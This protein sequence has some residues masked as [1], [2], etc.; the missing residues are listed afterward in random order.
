MNDPRRT[1]LLGVVLILIGRGVLADETTATP[2]LTG[3]RTVKDAA[4]RTIVPARPGVAGRTGYLGASTIRDDQGRLTIEQVQPDSPAS[5]AGVQPGDVIARVDGEPVRTPDLFREAI[6]AHAPGEPVKLAL[7]RRGQPIESTATLAA[8]SRP[9]SANTRRAYLGIAMGEA[10]EGE[11]VRVDRVEPD[12][13][14]ATAGFKPG[15]RIFQIDG[16]DFTTA[17]KLTEILTEKQ[18]GN[19]FEVT[20]RRDGAEVVLR[21]KLAA[22]QGGFRPGGAGAPGRPGQPGQPG[23]P[24]GG[25]GRGQGGQMTIPLW[26]KP[27][28]RVAVIG[29]EFPDV[30]HNAKV[31]VSDW[32]EAWLGEGTY[33]GKKSPT[34]QD[35]RGSLND[36]FVEQSA[37]AFRLKGKVFDWIEV[38]KK[39][40]DYILGSGTTSITAVLVEA[41]EKV[42]ARD[43]QDALK[44]FDG[45]LFVYA[46]ET[47]RGNRGSVYYP[48]AGTIRSFQSKRWSYVL[49]PEGGPRQ[50]ML[51]GVVKEFAQ[52]LGLPDLAA[53][54]EDR[55]SEGLGPWSV[56]SNPTR[57]PQPQHLDPWSKEKLG[58]LK[59]TVIDP[60]VKQKLILGPIEGSA[61]ECFKV[62][63]RPDG[64][65]YFLLENR[66]K[67]GFDEGLPAEGL[68]IWRVVKDR[69]SLVESHGIE[70]PTGP[71]VRLDAVPY[72][73]PA[74][75]AFTSET[76]PSS[77]STLGGG[78]PV[79]I[80]NIRRLPDGRIAFQ[81]GYDYL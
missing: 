18:P 21:P 68:L 49:I 60:T 39:R 54:T 78:L 35:V 52:M 27:E 2:D 34:D 44:D 41:L 62:L 22:D 65:E 72:P 43:G 30:K 42:V 75:H 58:W 46:G 3:Y 40:A 9:R 67:Q 13:P 77:R 33:H 11:G 45:V 10:K 69:P 6:Q 80:T 66:R 23:Q 70:G 59:P 5:K 8:T 50:T 19:E 71:T 81:I 17:A 57:G 36:Y 48:H 24:G 55:G 79:S 38:G 56:Q 16:L 63:V 76:T 47:I 37:G 64:S 26:I 1:A 74:N 7:I 32:D 15:D 4:T 14:A 25:Q 31:S 29:I 53:R 73:S 51:G 20:V 61:T 28:F 12:S